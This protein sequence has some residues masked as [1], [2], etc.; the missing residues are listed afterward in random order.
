MIVRDREPRGAG[1]FERLGW[2]LLPWALVALLVLMTIHYQATSWLFG[3][4][5]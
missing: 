4:C 1:S 2:A 5:Q 3:W